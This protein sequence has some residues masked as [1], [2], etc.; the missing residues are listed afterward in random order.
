MNVNV[1]KKCKCIKC[2]KHHVKSG[3]Y[4]TLDGKNPLTGKSKEFKCSKQKFSDG[5]YYIERNEK[6]KR[7]K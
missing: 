7:R 5:L 2:T 3:T 1:K 6:R 4:Y